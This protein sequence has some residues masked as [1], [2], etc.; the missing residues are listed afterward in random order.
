LRKAVTAARQATALV[1]GAIFTA[2]AVS[3][4]GYFIAPPYLPAMLYYAVALFVVG[5]A[6]ARAVGHAWIVAVGTFFGQAAQFILTADIMPLHP[7]LLIGL[8]FMLVQSLFALI[9]AW[10]GEIL[11][12]RGSTPAD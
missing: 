9:G 7:M 3:L 6:V 10:I 12:R 5:I 8:A 1:A 4:E 2:I 11:R